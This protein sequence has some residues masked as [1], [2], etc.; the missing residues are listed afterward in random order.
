M[1][2]RRMKV[3]FTFL[4]DEPFW[5]SDD[6]IRDQID[7]IMKGDNVEDTLEFVKVEDL[8]EVE[9]EDEYEPDFVE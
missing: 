8:G 5:W 4:T 2:R 6:A 3:E 7:F 9:E 1:K